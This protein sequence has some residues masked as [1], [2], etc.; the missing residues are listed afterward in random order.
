MWGERAPPSF[1]LL[2]QMPDS[3]W[4][5]FFRR[6][7]TTYAGK[8]RKE[9]GKNRCQQFP[10]SGKG[11]GRKLNNLSAAG[12]KW[13]NVCCLLPPSELG[14][15]SRGRHSDFLNSFFWKVELRDMGS[16]CGESVREKEGG[17]YWHHCRHEY[18]GN[19]EAQLLSPIEGGETFMQK[20]RELL[21]LSK[22]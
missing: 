9:G 18:F 20:I 15:D 8:D 13:E 11:R 4:G 14:A 21:F 1:R 22:I 2:G 7:Y 17:I 5:I 3:L 10:A 19:G 6:S 16:G 12:E